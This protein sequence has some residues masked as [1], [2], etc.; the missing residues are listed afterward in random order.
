MPLQWEQ[1]N[2]TCPFSF[3][4][5]LVFRS[6]LIIDEPLLYLPAFIQRGVEPRKHCLIILD[7]SKNKI[8]QEMEFPPKEVIL[9]EI[10]DHL[11][12]KD[13][14]FIRRDCFGKSHGSIL[15]A[16]YELG[17]IKIWQI[18]LI[19]DNKGECKREWSVTHRLKLE[20]M[21]ENYKEC[22]KYAFKGRISF[23][24]FHP[25]NPQVIFLACSE[26]KY[27]YDVNSSRFEL[28]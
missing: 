15:Y 13:C 14:N 18:L 20:T 3:Y 21:V 23:I 25:M 19:T 17:Q 10:D 9:Q 7:Q 26:K 1:F 28:I 12:P 5:D 22:L 8:I 16:C 2:L 4:L 11:P 24:A 6:S 27:L